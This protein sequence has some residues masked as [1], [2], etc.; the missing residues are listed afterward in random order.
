MAGPTPEYA[1]ALVARGGKIV[2]AG[3]AAGAAAAAGPGAA[4]VD[5]KGRT[6]VPGLI[7]T[8][9][10]FLLAAHNSLNADLRG[11]RDIPQLISMLREHAKTVPPGLWIEG[12]GFRVPLL[13]EGRFPTAE[14]L[15]KVSTTVPVFIQDGSGHHVVGNSLLLKQQNITKDTK[16]PPGGLLGARRTRAWPPRATAAPGRAR[17]DATN[18]RSLGPH[19]PLH[20]HTRDPFCHRWR[21]LPQARHHRARRPHRRGARDCALHAA[22]ADA[23]RRG[24]QGGQQLGAAVARERVHDG[25]RAG[26]GHQRRRP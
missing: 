10:H 13:K 21:V 14:D 26:A 25:Q 24:T 8:H 22:P 23:A 6:L 12:M 11:A 19:P 2:Y 16:D 9:A 1:E 18:R 5:L 20:T 7:D 15:D 4:R 17:L 3:P